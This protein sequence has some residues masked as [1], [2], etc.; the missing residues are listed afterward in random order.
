MPVVNNFK[1]VDLIGNNVLARLVNNLVMVATA[2]RD[3]Q[4]PWGANAEYKVGDTVRIRKPVYYTVASGAPL[5]LQAIEERQ[6]TLTIDYQKHVDV[7]L[8]SVEVQRFLQDPETNVYEGAA[9]AL[10]NQMDYDIITAG[11]NKIYRYVGTPGSGITSFSVP[12]AA[13]TEQRKYAVVNSEYMCFNN[14]DA[15]TLRNAL[16]NSF[17]VP[18]NTDIS[19]RAIL[20]NFGGHDIY[21]DQNMQM[22]TTGSMAGTP[23]VDGADQDG[24]SINLKGFTNSAA[25]VLKKGDIISFAGVYGV[26]PVNRMQVGT[27]SG[28]LARFVVTDASVSADGS[29]DAT[30]NIE[31][32]IVTSGPYQNVTASPADNAAVTCAGVTVNGTAATYSNNFVYSRDAFTLA[33]VPGPVMMGAPYCKVFTDSDTGISLRVTVTYTPQSDSDIIRF[34]TFYGTTC[35]PEYATRIIG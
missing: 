9:Q 31:P 2:N 4:S 30:V 16:Q 8:T 19:Q 15:G 7:S 25:G 1:V 27:G 22:H 26:N 10:A 14:S 17:N 35:F 29:G 24:S 6:T 28:N 23:L 12:N 18:F 21:E 11:L 33:C 3:W 5:D 34:D 20:G 32:A 13:I